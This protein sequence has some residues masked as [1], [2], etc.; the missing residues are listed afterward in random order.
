MPR[1]SP[2]P[3]ILEYLPYR[4]RDGTAARDAADPSLFRRPWLCRVR[5]D[6]RGTGES[7]GLLQDEYLKQEQDDACEV[8]AWLAAQPWCTGAVGMIGISWGGFNGLQVAARRPPALKAVISLCS[9]DDRYADDVH[10]MGGCLLIDNLGWG[11]TMFGLQ[12]LPPDPALV[13]ERW[14]E[15]WLERL[16][17]EPLA[18]RQLAAASAPRRLLEAWLGLR[19]LRRRSPARSMPWAAGPTAIPT[20]SRACWQGLQMPEQGADRPLGP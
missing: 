14:R 15:M 7:D 5:V 17:N 8:I 16:E 11:S 13:G 1:S 6:I 9:T 19:G 4:K 2:V 18:G 12:S 20:R 3:A 10:Y